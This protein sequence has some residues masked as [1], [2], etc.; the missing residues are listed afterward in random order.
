MIPH[1]Y[2]YKTKTIKPISKTPKLLN[3]KSKYAKSIRGK[4]IATKREAEGCL[5][6]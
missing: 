4:R 1:A 2:P 6:E 5:K 3:S